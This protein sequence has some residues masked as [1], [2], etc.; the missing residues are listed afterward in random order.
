M[1]ELVYWNNLDKKTQS[2]L[3]GIPSIFVRNS[4]AVYRGVNNCYSFLSNLA[5]IYRQQQQA[6]GSSQGPAGPQDSGMMMTQGL[7]PQGGPGAAPAP[8]EGEVIYG[9]PPGYM[10]PPGTQ[11]LQGN[12]IPGV[13]AASQQR[14]AQAPQGLQQGPQGAQ[15]QLSPQSPAAP[16]SGQPELA[17]CS[18]G[19]RKQMGAPI[20]NGTMAAEFYSNSP[21]PYVS[22]GPQAAPQV[23]QQQQQQPMQDQYQQQ[24]PS[25]FD[26]TGIPGPVFGYGN[27]NR[28][29]QQPQSHEYMRQAMMQQ[30]GPAGLQQGGSA[31]FT[32]QGGLQSLP[33]KPFG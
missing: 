30:G 1:I 11:L 23:A 21:S 17:Y 7:Q 14:R 10:A 16:F 3:R 18:L 20:G 13:S 12:A 29:Q 22:Q 15:A 9:A 2:Y 25:Q 31:P 28:R 24:Q 5:S 6:Q 19:S 4:G 8:P 32:Q 27:D 33:M 26:M